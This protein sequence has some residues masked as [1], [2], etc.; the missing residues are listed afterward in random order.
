VLNLDPGPLKIEPQKLLKMTPVYFQQLSV[1]IF[2][3]EKAPEVQ[4]S[5]LKLTPGQFSTRFKILRYTGERL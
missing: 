1:S 2:N 3:G 4:Y 5:T